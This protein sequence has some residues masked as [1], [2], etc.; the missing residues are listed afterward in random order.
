MLCP[1]PSI[2][3]VVGCIIAKA[4]V[5]RSSFV[6]RTV[7]LLGCAKTKLA[8]QLRQFGSAARL[9][10]RFLSPSSQYRLRW[11]FHCSQ[12]STHA[13]Y[14]SCQPSRAVLMVRSITFKSRTARVPHTFHGGWR[15]QN[16][17]HLSRIFG[18]NSLHYL[19]P[20]NWFKSFASL[21]GTG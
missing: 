16:R 9:T 1:N 19:A 6:K 4:R 7:S 13:L 3:S 20:N 14:L 5:L 21:T 2:A 17:G 8:R 15:A 18:S 12:T 11:C 10:A